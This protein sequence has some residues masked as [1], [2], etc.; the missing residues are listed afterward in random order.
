MI[1]NEMQNNPVI[2]VRDLTKRFRFFSSP[3]HS[4]K[5]LLVRAFQGEF[6]LEKPREF[7]ALNG[8]NF[9][10]FAGEFVGIMGRN[11]AGKSTLLK[12]ISGI[13]E[14]SSGSIAV[15]GK[16]APMIEL[17][18]GFNPDLTGYEN[19]FLNAAILGFGRKITKEAIPIF[20]NFLN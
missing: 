11:G 1:Q 4:L 19:I 15:K 10:I 17:G 16:I 13:Y 3:S 14:P 7:T 20:W 9:K 12:I 8:L 5:T 18:A 6:S 2:E